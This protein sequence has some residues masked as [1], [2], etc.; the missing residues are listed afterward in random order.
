MKLFGITEYETLLSLQDEVKREVI[1]FDDVKYSIPGG[2]KACRLIASEL[3]RLGVEFDFKA[4]FYRLELEPSEELE[5]QLTR[6][7]QFTGDFEEF[8]ILIS[9]ILEHLI[10]GALSFS[11]QNSLNLQI[12]GVYSQPEFWDVI[13]GAWEDFRIQGNPSLE[14][15][16]LPKV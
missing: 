9:E 6:D 8:N 14:D 5:G 11:D 3:N 1:E 13:N 7:V 2:E 10:Q 12:L 16:N 15:D 4:D